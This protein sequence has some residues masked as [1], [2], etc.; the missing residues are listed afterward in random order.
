MNILN[1]VGCSD[2][3]IILDCSFFFDQKNI[4]LR[5]HYRT[6]LLEIPIKLNNLILIFFQKK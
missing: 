4:S 2:F 5:G 1:I 3:N 6:F